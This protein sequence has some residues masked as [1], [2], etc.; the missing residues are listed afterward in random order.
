MCQVRYST[1]INIL[2]MEPLGLSE[3]D[4]YVCHNFRNPFEYRVPGYRE[5]DI[6]DGK[7]IDPDADEDDLELEVAFKSDEETHVKSEDHYPNVLPSMGSTL[8]DEELDDQSPG[9][10]TW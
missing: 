8:G 3:H 9:F 4:V 1:L 5:E 10:D 2:V 7:V 6:I